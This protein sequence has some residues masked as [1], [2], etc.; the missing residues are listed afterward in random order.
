MFGG[1]YMIDKCEAA[2]LN[3]QAQNAIVGVISP[4][5]W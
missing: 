4:V 1:K 2:Q 5:R 3:S